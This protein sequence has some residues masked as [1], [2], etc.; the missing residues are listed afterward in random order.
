MTITTDIT[1]QAYERLICYAMDTSDVALLVYDETPESVQTAAEWKQRVYETLPDFQA[2]ELIEARWQVIEAKGYEDCRI[3]EH[4]KR[5]FIKELEP[6]RIKVRHNPEWPSTEVFMCPSEYTIA[7]YGICPEL[8]PLLLRPQSY[9]AW[10][11][12]HYPEDLSFFDDHRAWLFAS[13]HEGY[14]EFYPRSQED[15]DMV[16]SFGIELDEPYVPIPDEK[17][18]YEDYEYVKPKH[19]PSYYSCW[20]RWDARFPKEG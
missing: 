2:D 10:R 19:T 17:R 15:Y 18:F 5:P 14:I 11:Y 1:G 6:Y 13:S 4:V 12:P 20:E 3:F 16:K 9:L 8:L 7:L